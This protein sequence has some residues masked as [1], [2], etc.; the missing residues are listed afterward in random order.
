MPKH[1]R[2]IVVPREES[3]L[4]RAIGEAH[5]RYTRQINFREKWRGYLWQGL[6]GSFPLDE[7]CLLAAARY[8]EPNPVKAGMVRAAWDYAWSSV[9]AHLSGR[10][11]GVVTVEP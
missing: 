8:L 2:L 6:F 3:R 4:S 5:R 11:D 7:P 9:H 1:V 10:S